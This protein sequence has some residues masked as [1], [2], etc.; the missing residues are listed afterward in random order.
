MKTLDRFFV[1]SLL[2]TI[3]GLLL[4]LMWQKT[5][6]KGDTSPVTDSPK[7]EW[8][9]KLNKRLEQDE[10]DLEVRRFDKKLNRIGVHN[11]QQI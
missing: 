8:V 7:Q 2:F 1:Y 11:E 5:S 3:L 9:S 10:K 4:F 6:K